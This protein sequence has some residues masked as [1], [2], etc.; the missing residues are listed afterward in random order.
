MLAA[1]AGADAALHHSKVVATGK[2]GVV[3]AVGQREEYQTRV[4]G[5]HRTHWHQCL[6]RGQP[7][8]L[9]EGDTGPRRQI[10][11]LIDDA[12]APTKANAIR[13]AKLLTEPF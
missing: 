12:T 5:L 11:P 2:L 13:C 10:G 6:E 9:I 1:D 8:I 7:R 3:G 4:P